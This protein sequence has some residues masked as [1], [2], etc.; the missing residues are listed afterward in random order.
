MKVFFIAGLLTV[1]ALTNAQVTNSK[2]CQTLDKYDL[3]YL[4]GILKNPTRGEKCNDSR[5]PLKFLIQ[6]DSG[7]KAPFE[8][9][10]IYYSD[11]KNKVSISGQ[12]LLKIDGKIIPA[13]KVVIIQPA[14]R[15][16]WD[17]T[18]KGYAYARGLG[19]CSENS[20]KLASGWKTEDEMVT[21][22]EMVNSPLYK[23]AVKKCVD[24]V[25]KS[26]IDQVK[27]YLSKNK[28]TIVSITPVKSVL[29]N[30]YPDTGMEFLNYPTTIS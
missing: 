30:S 4:Q 27:S 25:T 11:L 16:G 3:E 2:N 20:L 26:P 15:E 19:E 29:Q 6:H 12:N 17:E 18:V 23:K 24:Q 7:D 22:M 5:F 9:Q 1:S 28:A 8:V 21:K 13:S 14:C 10:N